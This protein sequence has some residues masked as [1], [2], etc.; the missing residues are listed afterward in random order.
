MGLCLSRELFYQFFFLQV[1]PVAILQVRL[2]L[3]PAELLQ[4]CFGCN[5][6]HFLWSTRDDSALHW[7]AWMEAQ[8]KQKQLHKD[9]L[10]FLSL[11]WWNHIRKKWPPKKKKKK[12]QIT[13][14]KQNSGRIKTRSEKWTIICCSLRISWFAS[15]ASRSRCCRLMCHSVCMESFASFFTRCVLADINHRIW[16]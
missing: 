13:N 7:S 6:F 1:R 5:F 10:V 4:R 16:E 8:T 3:L 14:D 11:S 15:W 9:H 2:N 12:S